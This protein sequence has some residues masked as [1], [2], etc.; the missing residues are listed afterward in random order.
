MK[1]VAVLVAV[2]L[3]ACSSQSVV[4][5]LEV[6][7]QALLLPEAIAPEEP[8]ADRVTVLTMTGKNLV[9]RHA[10]IGRSADALVVRHEG[11]A[12]TIPL[13]IAR[14]VQIERN[15]EGPHAEALKQRGEQDEITVVPTWTVVLGLVVMATAVGFIVLENEDN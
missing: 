13:E 8:L 4:K 10:I 9:Y 15:L 11:P 1:T 2:A 7:E 12:A 14:A 3:L 6:R 5:R